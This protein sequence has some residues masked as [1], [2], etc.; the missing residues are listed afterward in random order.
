MA[1]VPSKATTTTT[2]TAKSISSSVSSSSSNQRHNRRFLQ[3]VSR[4]SSS[5]ST[6]ETGGEV[7]GSENV[8]GGAEDSRE[9]I[10]V[11]DVSDGS[12]PLSGSSN[13]IL[14]GITN[15]SQSQP[16]DN[17]KSIANPTYDNPLEEGP[18]TLWIANENLHR[19]IIVD[20][21][22]RF[23]A[24]VKVKNPIGLLYVPEKDWVFVG[25]KKSNKETG[26][27]YAVNVTSFEVMKKYTL[28]GGSTMD[29]P[30]GLAVYD[31][32]LY[33]AEQSMN[34]VLSFNVT[35]GRYIKQ[36]IGKLNVDG[37]ESLTLS[38]C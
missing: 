27:V 18:G 21:L 12:T 38:D 23:V 20:S 28:L 9:G 32:I 19:V 10:V 15:P 34:V 1:W 4:S 25:S 5:K 37:I 26:A 29:H 2:T 35:S 7:D 22:G 3:D 11:G 31:D 30:T 6:G 8:N 33:V 14:D 24:R 16:N 17:Q 36:V 13:N